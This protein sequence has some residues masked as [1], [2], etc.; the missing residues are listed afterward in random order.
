MAEISVEMQAYKRM[1]K[2]F[3]T[4]AVI[5]LFASALAF[6][7]AIFMFNLGTPPN[8]LIDGEQYRLWMIDHQQQFMFKEAGLFYWTEIDTALFAAG[9][10][11]VLLLISLYLFQLLVVAKIAKVTAKA[12]ASS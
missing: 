10:A 9:S 12:F 3:L 5:S 4:W 7:V 1:M 2:R 6:G 11:A 8:A